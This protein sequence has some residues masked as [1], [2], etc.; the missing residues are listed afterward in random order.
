MSVITIKVDDATVTALDGRAREHGHTP[1][2]EAGRVLSAALAEPDNMA[3]RLRARFEP[4]GGADL[5]IPDRPV[6]RDLPFT[7]V[8]YDDDE[9]DAD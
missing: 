5:P 6:T 3:K 1:E 9:T 4:L 7:F 2:E 8:P